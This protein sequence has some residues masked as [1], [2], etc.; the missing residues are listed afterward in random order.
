VLTVAKVVEPKVEVGEAANEV[1]ELPPK[2]LTVVELELLAVVGKL[3]AAVDVGA[4]ASTG[5]TETG[6]PTPEH[7]DTTTLE[8]ATRRGLER[9]RRR[10]ECVFFIFVPCWSATSQACLTQGTTCSTR[11]DFWQWQAKSVSSE[12]PSEP[13]AEVRQFSCKRPTEKRPGVSF[14]T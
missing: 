9:I 1:R 12:Q 5:G 14:P 8:T 4:D 10:V 11:P 3:A 7:K 6:W 13:R 2:P